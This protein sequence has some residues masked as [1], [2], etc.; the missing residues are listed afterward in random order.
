MITPAPWLVD[1]DSVSQIALGASV[2]YLTLGDRLGKRALLVGGA[3]GTLPDLD[4]VVPYADAIASF[5][6]HRSWSHSLFVLSAISPLCAWLTSRFFKAS[7]MSFKQCWFGVW[8]VLVTH[9]LLD[10]FTLY[11]TQIWWPLNLPPT[12]WG[13]VFIIDPL[14]TV[15]LLIACSIAWRRSY[16]KARTVMIAALA[17]STSYLIWT[18][19]AQNT[20]RERLERTLSNQQIQA[21]STLIAPFPLSL[22]WR[23]V[24]VTDNH[25]YEGFSSLLDQQASIH[26]SRYENGKDACK[27]WLTHWPVKRLDWFTNGHYSLSV[28]GDTLVA[29]D[30]RMGIEDSY[31]FEFAIAKWQDTDWQ[32]IQTEQMPL[33]I[34]GARMRLLFSRMLD[35]SVDLS[36]VITLPENQTLCQ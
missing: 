12:A 25:Y 17:L 21:D 3:L 14:Y 6:F 16:V 10:G 2:A 18:L 20:I 22:L 15:P 26:L 23:T 31:V 8:L 11:G 33:S 9:P 28:Q 27:Q 24:A 1:L 4:V 29:S 35:E 7:A 13:S 19:A 5:T 30:L 32:I 34:D 36:P